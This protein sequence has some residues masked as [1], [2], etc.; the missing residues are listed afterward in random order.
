MGVCPS[1]GR[2]SASQIN[3]M[4]AT[5]SPPVTGNGEQVLVDRIGENS[6]LRADGR[7]SGGRRQRH[8]HKIG[9]PDPDHDLHRTV[10]GEPE[11]LAR[12][13][14]RAD[15]TSTTVTAPRSTAYPWSVALR[16]GDAEGDRACA[17]QLK[18]ERLGHEPRAEKADG[19]SGHRSQTTVDAPEEGSR[20]VRH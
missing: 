15:M 19:R 1:P 2:S 20:N 14:E 13:L 10:D 7:R 16:S 6:G 3:G 18:D 12:R 9:H 17:D 5:A 4:Q 11:P 8:L